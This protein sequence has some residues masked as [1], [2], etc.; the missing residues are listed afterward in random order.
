[1]N[2]GM[3]GCL[4]PSVTLSLDSGFSAEDSVPSLMH[5]SKPVPISLDPLYSSW[6][7]QASPCFAGLLVDEHSVSW[8]CVFTSDLD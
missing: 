1:M 4:S 5:A 8:S 7:N 2:E 6:Q 3:G